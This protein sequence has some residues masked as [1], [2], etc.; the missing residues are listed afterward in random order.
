M[1]RLIKLVRNLHRVE[2]DRGNF[3]DFCVYLQRNRQAR[4]APVD[5]EYFEFF[6]KKGMQ[7]GAKKVYN[8]FVQIYTP[9]SCN[10]EPF[11]LEMITTISD[12]YGSDAEEMDIWLTVI[13]GGMIAEENKKNAVLKKK[14]KR[15]GMHQVLMQEMDPIVAANFS[16]GKKINELNPIIKAAG[17]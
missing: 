9:A 16:R 14:I 11:I 17:F 13:Y 12:T 2:F 6:L 7:Y 10:L 3:D 4:Y 1:S 15:L 8:D 5:T